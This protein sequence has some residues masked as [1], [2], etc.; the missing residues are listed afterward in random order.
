MS[1]AQIAAQPGAE[2][3]GADQSGASGA[4]L[5]QP[6]ASR[7]ASPRAPV[8]AAFGDGSGAAIVFRDYASI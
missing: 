6:G 1:N 2:Q 4:R 3:A 5:S 8:Q 7:S